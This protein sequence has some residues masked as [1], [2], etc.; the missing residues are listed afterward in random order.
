MHRKL[1]TARLGLRYYVQ[2]SSSRPAFRVP[3]PLSHNPHAEVTR[4]DDDMTFIRRPPP[5]APTP[6]STTLS[7]SSP[8]LTSYAEKTSLDVSLPP[9]LKPPKENLRLSVTLTPEQVKEVRKLRRE[10]SAQW[11]ASR[12]AARFGCTTHLISKVAALRVSERRAKRSDQESA[13][14]LIRASW[15]ERRATDNMVRKRRREFW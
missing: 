10:D 9:T 3:D 8:L 4:L 12:L 1:P 11:T 5:S 13:H 7:P 2:G 15:S 6:H 14:V